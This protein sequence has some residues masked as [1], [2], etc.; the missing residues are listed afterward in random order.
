METNSLAAYVA[1]RVG[2]GLSKKEIREELL[3]VGWSDEEADAAYR[4]G[5]IALGIPIPSEGS[6]PALAR[7]SSTVD[8]VTNFFSFILLGIA[9]TALGTLYFQ[10]INKRFPD[11]LAALNGSG[12]WAV[13]SAIHYAIASLLIAFPLYF[14]AMRIWFRKF[15]EDEGR[16]ESALSRWLTY[17]VL[18]VASVTIVGDLIT[19]LFKLLQGGITARF[20]LKAL[21]ILVIAGVVFGFY[22]LERR[23]IQY[24]RDIP[25]T[26]FQ[27]FG[28]SVAGIV[29]L[30]LI[31][32]FLAAGSPETARKRAFDMQ[33][34]TDLDR[35]AG[36]IERYA[37][38]LGQLPVSLEALRKSGRY[39]HC[40]SP[41]QDP[42]TKR[43]YTYR[44][45]TPSRIQ[46][47]ARVGEFELCASFSLAS[48]GYRSEAGTDDG[49][50]TIWNAHGAGLSC[51]TVSVQ[52]GEKTAPPV[53]AGSAS[54]TLEPIK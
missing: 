16:T 48:A 28:W 37:R 38:D 50:V 14:A 29:A 22:T 1:G 11:P 53:P 15:R 35:L 17:L 40:A 49:G 18:L 32:G 36:C 47:P 13:T 39:A 25:R 26:T 12:E 43:G 45:V 3:A 41:M 54:D 24:R 27:Y 21:T 33:R 46:G 30:G 8:I 20:F 31:L 10:I 52:L 2:A 51:D 9:A 34:E 23:K 5:L 42:E 7:K 6:R 4:D 19:V 44:I